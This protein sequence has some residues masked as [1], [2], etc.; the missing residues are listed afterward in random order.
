MITPKVPGFPCRTAPPQSPRPAEAVH[1][2]TRSPMSQNPAGGS[3]QGQPAP[4]TITQDIQ[5]SQVSARVPEKVSPGVHSSGVLLLNGP[6][7]FI[8]DFLQ[9]LVQPPKVAA[10]VVMTPQVLESFARALEENNG[11]YEQKF[12]TPPALPAPPPGAKPTPIDELYA[13]LKLPDEM[14]AGV[15]ANAVMISHGPSDFVLD[16][17]ATFYPRS[18]V[19]AR[20]FMSAKQIPPLLG[21]MRQALRQYHERQAREAG[22]G[23]APGQN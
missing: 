17:L 2:E 23:P 7:E 15:Y 5:F 4:D 11:L 20:V 18:A 8:L 10:R 1:Q 9:Q 16:F 21:T 6:N 13:Q 14:L 19:S 12:G 3:P 22:R